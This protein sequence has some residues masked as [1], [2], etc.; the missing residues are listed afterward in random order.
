MASA[1]TKAEQASETPTPAKAPKTDVGQ[2][3]LQARRDR[4]EAQ[5][6]AGVEVDQEPNSTYTA[7]SGGKD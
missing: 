7:P 2:A 6:F 5:G 3:E 4:Q 1:K